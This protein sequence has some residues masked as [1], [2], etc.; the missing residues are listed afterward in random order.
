MKLTVVSGEGPWEPGAIFDAHWHLQL[1]VVSGEPPWE[2]GRELVATLDNPPEDMP[3][4][5]GRVGRVSGLS[6]WTETPS[7]SPTPNTH[8]ALKDR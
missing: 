6:H 5:P 8:P 7:G 1:R 4:I 2:P 3:I